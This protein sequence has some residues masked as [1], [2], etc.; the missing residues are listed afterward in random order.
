MMV[1]RMRLI[2]PL[3][4]LLLVS[5]VPQPLSRPILIAHRG[6]SGVAPEHTLAAYAQAIADG[7]DYIEPDLVMSKDGV[8]V[9]R[10]ENEISG[11]TDVAARSEFADRKRTKTID[12][13]AVTGWFAEDFTLAELKTLRARERLPQLRRESAKL[14]GRYPIATFTE[15]IALVRA[16]ERARGRRI[17]LYPETKHPG[18]FDSIGLSF[19]KPMLAALKAGG[20][21]RAWDPVFIQSFEPANLKRLRGKT[22]L[23]LVQLI[24][25]QGGPADTP[26]LSYAEMTTPAGYRAI[27]R[28]AD[29][30]GLNKNL[31]LPRDAAQNWLAP[32]DTVRAAKAAGLAVHVWTF[33]AE[34]V[35]LPANLRRG[36]DPAAH[37]DLAAEIARFRAFGVDGIFSDHVAEVAAALR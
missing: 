3:V 21:K 6:A 35:F 17:G 30:V 28:Y 29:G 34:N 14:D 15:A 18:Y 33:R 2:L 23:K 22:M 7:A 24:D 16:E 10:H 19:D 9:I 27:A 20:Y 12:G 25:A 1:T 4:A 8:P 11:T 5:A 31:I 26:G 13:T 37:G 32:T 36:S